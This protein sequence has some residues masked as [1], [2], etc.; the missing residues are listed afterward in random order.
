MNNKDDDDILL[1]QISDI[2]EG[3]DDILSDD[4][5]SKLIVKD[6]KPYHVLD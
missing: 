3:L 6:T 5:L 1:Q 4:Y 2:S